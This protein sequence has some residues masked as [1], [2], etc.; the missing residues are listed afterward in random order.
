M[1]ITRAVNDSGTITNATVVGAT[2]T[3][4]VTGAKFRV[5]AYVN[6]TV[7]TTMS[8]SVTYT[9]KDTGGTPRTDTFF[10]TS[11]S[12]LT[13]LNSLIIAAARYS[14]SAIINTG[15]ALTQISI[16]TAGT[17]TATTYTIQS[18]IEE[19]QVP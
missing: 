4:T 12:G 6:V 1:T 2:Y 15:G 9:Y 19:L 18:G 14:C 7:G 11:S 8:M 17:V 16:Q 3:P 5:W 10:L 13:P